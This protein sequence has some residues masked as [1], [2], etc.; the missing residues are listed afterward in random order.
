MKE[1]IV[2]DEDVESIIKLIGAGGDMASIT[3][4]TVNFE[5]GILAKEGYSP[6][7]YGS[8]DTIAD[9]INESF[10]TPPNKASSGRVTTVSSKQINQ[11][12]AWLHQKGVASVTRR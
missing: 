7:S 1:Y 4:D 3:R 10:G 5:A 8:G 11:A 9:A 6:V 2:T 12:M